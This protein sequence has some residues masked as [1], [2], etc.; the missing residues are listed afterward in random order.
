METR[1]IKEATKFGVILQE[2]KSKSDE[3]KIEPSF[4]KEAEAFPIKKVQS[5]SEGRIDF[6]FSVLK[7]VDIEYFLLRSPR[8]E[9][10]YF[11]TG[12]IDGK[13][14]IQCKCYLFKRSN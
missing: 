4:M 12:T 5:L 8:F 14:C 10:P 6:L 1:S 7:L 13:D 2:V 9:N 11:M 3:N